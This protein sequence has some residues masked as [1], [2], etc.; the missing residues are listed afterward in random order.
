MCKFELLSTPKTESFDSEML[1][2][3]LAEKDVLISINRIKNNILKTRKVKI[4]E[5]V[6]E[7]N[8][9]VVG[10]NCI[11]SKL[12]LK[13]S[14][15]DADNLNIS[16]TSLDDR[17]V[18]ISVNFNVFC[19]LVEI[20]KDS[21]MRRKLGQLD[22]TGRINKIHELMDLDDEVKIKYANRISEDLQVFF[23]LRQTGELQRIEDWGED[24]DIEKDLI[25]I[26]NKMKA[27]V[28]SREGLSLFEMEDKK[29]GK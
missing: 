29:N 7:N 6:F 8:T 25:N 15:G 5:S 1:L 27:V 3:M 24:E 2:W 11:V 20:L 12:L 14:K 18:E 13:S 10:N 21:T 23:D 26:E 22:K 28:V 4:P 17:E 16:I 19:S 9:F